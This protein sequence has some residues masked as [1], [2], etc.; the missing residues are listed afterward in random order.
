MNQ[1]PTGLN[2]NI[3]KSLRDFPLQPEQRNAQSQEEGLEQ[4][5]HWLEDRD[6]LDQS[7]VP[8]ELHEEGHDHNE[9]S[10]NN[11]IVNH[12]LL[13]AG[14]DNVKHLYELFRKK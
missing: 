1:T 9:Q 8:Q 5:I 13:T 12:L 11:N 3:K 7:A 6:V 2:R 10:E 4:R 14:L